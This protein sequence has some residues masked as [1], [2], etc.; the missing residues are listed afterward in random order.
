MVQYTVPE[1][2]DH[3]VG[4]FRGQHPT[5]HNTG[6]QQRE[7]E[8]ASC[9]PGTM[10]ICKVFPLPS[11][12]WWFTTNWVPKGGLAAPMEVAFPKRSHLEEELA[13]E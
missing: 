6:L 10:S 11:S 5:G 1:G 2:K 3:S 8:W 4:I 13:S 9:P 12:H 7:Q